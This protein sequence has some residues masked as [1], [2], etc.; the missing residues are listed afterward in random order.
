MPSGWMP[1][2]TFAR[3]SEGETQRGVAYCSLHSYP[4]KECQYRPCGHSAIGAD[5]RAGRGLFPKPR[6]D[7][8]PMLRFGVPKPAGHGYLHNADSDLMHHQCRLS[9]PQWNP[10]PARRN[11]THIIAA[12]C[13]RFHAVLQQETS[14]HVLHVTDQ[15]IACTGDTDHAILLNRDTCE[16]NP[17]VYAF[18]EVST[19]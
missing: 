3:F 9:V 18:Q 1:V 19:S 13:G 7:V 6:P 15:F 2:S 16:P 8:L 11:P 10:G 17:A 5:P 14:D 4:Q 12:T